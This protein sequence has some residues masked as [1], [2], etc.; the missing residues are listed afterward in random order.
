MAARIEASDSPASDR[1]VADLRRWMAPAILACLQLM[2]I[3]D[4]A[5]ANVPFR[6]IRI[7]LLS[8]RA[9]L[10]RVLD[11]SPVTALPT[12]RLGSRLVATFSGWRILPTDTIAVAIGSLVSAANQDSS[13]CASGR[14]FLR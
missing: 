1:R 2:Q 11:V 8:S 14:E 5:F 3:L 7:G 6:S 9:T 10:V 13:Q 4:D 12:I